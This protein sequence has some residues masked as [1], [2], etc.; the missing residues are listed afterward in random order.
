MVEEA[1][2]ANDRSCAPSTPKSVDSLMNFK[3]GKAI[4]HAREG[5]TSKAVR[6]LM[7]QGT[8]KPADSWTVHDDDGNP[9]ERRVVFDWAGP[10][11]QR[12]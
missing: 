7:S 10:C 6:T 9:I 4:K 2:S 5:E 11:M 8:A 3:W 12:R 1:A